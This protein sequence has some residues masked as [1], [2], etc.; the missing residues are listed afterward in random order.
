[1]QSTFS[2]HI[3]AFGSMLSFSFFARRLDGKMFL[4]NVKGNP[5]DSMC[6]ASESPFPSSSAPIRQIQRENLKLQSYSRLIENA[7]NALDFVSIRF[8]VARKA[9]ETNQ[10]HLDS[11]RWCRPWACLLRT[12]S[13]QS[14]YPLFVDYCTFENW[15]R[16]RTNAFLLLLL[17]S[18]LQMSHSTLRRFSSRKLIRCLAQSSKMSSIRYG[19]TKS[20]SR[21]SW[22]RQIT[23]APANSKR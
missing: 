12:R 22:P 9:R 4:G 7:L 18:R 20:A 1:M 17:C 2:S 8:C 3:I 14:K 19:K 10:M 15:N 11:W 16:E 21:V 23:A 5:Y 6:T 13:V